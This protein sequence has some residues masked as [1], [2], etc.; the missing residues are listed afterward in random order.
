MPKRSSKPKDTQKLARSVLDAVALDA[1]PPKKPAASA[2]PY[3]AGPPTVFYVEDQPLRNLADKMKHL[4]RV[5]V[6]PLPEL[7]SQREL[8]EGQG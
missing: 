4:L 2:V 6:Q 8:F 5:S 7:E 1:E 3:R